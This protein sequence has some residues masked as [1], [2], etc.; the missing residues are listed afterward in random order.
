MKKYKVTGMSCAA[1]QA[2]VEKAVSGV[3][4]VSSCSVSLLTNSMG[5]EGSV[6]D[7]AII[8]AVEKAGYGAEIMEDLQLEDRESPVLAKRLISSIIILLFLMY[9]SMGHMMWGW[10]IP[11]F[12]EN[13]VTIAVVEMILAI[14]VMVINKKFFISGFRSLFSGAPN[15]D[16]LVALG[17]TASF[18]YSLVELIIMGKASSSGDMDTVMKYAMNLYFE[19]AAMIP[20]LITVGKL[21][22]AKSKG[23]T[24][25]ALKSLMK[26]APKKATV[27]RNAEEVEVD[28]EEVKVG[29]IYILRTGDRVPVDGVII[30]GNAA[31]DESALTGES[32]P[33][34]KEEGDTVSAGTIISNGF[35]KCSA[36]RVGEDTTLSQIIQMVGDA[37]A[38][39][40]PLARI[41]DKVSAIFVPVV[42]GLAV[43]T[44]IGWMIAGE[45]V[46]FGIAR[47][48]SVLVISCPCALGLATP[49]AIMVGNGMGARNGILYKTAEAMETIGRVGVVV[50][51]KTGTITKGEPGVTNVIPAEG[52]SSEGLITLAYSLEKMSEHPLA[53]AVV[54][55]AEKNNSSGVM[56][57]NFETL[58]GAGVKAEAAEDY[59]IS[60]V[61]IAKGTVVQ[62]GSYKYIKEQLELNKEKTTDIE[63]HKDSRGLEQKSSIKD[64]VEES[65]NESINDSIKDLSRQADELTNSGKTPLFFMVGDRFLGIIAVAD[66]IK[67]DSK[68]AIQELSNMGIYSIMLTGDNHN[69]AKVIAE[70]VGVNEVIAEVMPDEK[71][72]I[73][74]SLQ[75]IMLT[76]KGSHDKSSKEEHSKSLK[77]A[78]VGDGINDAVALTRADSGLAIGAGTDVAVDAADIVLVKSSIRDVAAAIRMS[79]AT[80]RNIHE[81]LFWAFFYNALCIP[82]AMGLYGIALKPMYGAAAMACS[83]VFVC[84]NALRLNLVKVYNGDHDKAPKRFSDQSFR[85]KIKTVVNEMKTNIE[86]EN[87]KPENVKPENSKPENIKG[88]TIMEKTIN[89]EGMMCTHCEATVKKALEALDGVDSA[90]VSHEKGT[91]VVSFSQEVADEVLTKA[92]EDKDYKVIAIK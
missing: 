29:D 4:G 2:R 31:M 85:D 67:E 11:G 19:S 44:F 33:V 18:G 48:I 8:E 41:A 21:L 47:A 70:E 14:V 90:I 88:E 20:T 73:I 60:G 78:M 89:I 38:T 87:I 6:S 42:M 43:L 79:R 37:A 52:V 16:T 69:T 25:D 7:K 40:A 58:S 54:R 77:V 64:S 68:Q 24:T 17:S 36:T 30:E 72:K 76:D 32:I 23:R 55:C 75:E 81:N 1:C 57:T 74:R 65:I 51:D 45:S 82:L 28:I 39:K 22:E 71:E 3:E 53:G 13:H 83:S 26:L 34:D 9:L 86:P 49:V 84:L 46:A 10:P 56:L 66:Q 15:M 92:V 91:A 12:L 50:M 35:L 63:K 5:I 27:F 80:I 62:G 59:N 61:E